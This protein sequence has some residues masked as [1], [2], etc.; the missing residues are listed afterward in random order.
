VPRNVSAQQTRRRHPLPRE[1]HRDRPPSSPPS[2]RRGD[3]R[4]TGCARHSRSRAAFTHRPLRTR[5]AGSHPERQGRHAHCSPVYAGG[6]LRRVPTRGGLETGPTRH[7][8][9]CRTARS[10]RHRASAKGGRAPCPYPFLAPASAARIGRSWTARHLAWRTF[11]V[12]WEPP[13]LTDVSPDPIAICASGTNATTSLV[14]KVGVHPG[15]G[16]SPAA[17]HGTQVRNEPTVDYL[18][19]SGH[20]R[21]DGCGP[22]RRRRSWRRTLTAD[23]LCVPPGWHVGRGQ[24]TP[25]AQKKSLATHGRDSCASCPG[26]LR[27]SSGALGTRTSPRRRGGGEAFEE[28]LR[29]GRRVTPALQTAAALLQLGAPITSPPRWTGASR[30][31]RAPR[32]RRQSPRW[33]APAARRLSPTIPPLAERRAARA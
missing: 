24:H 6:R 10:R 4:G 20:R 28:F 26:L 9:G 25:H 31:I 29:L 17:R 11:H 18:S 27:W 30:T 32:Q 2:G 22:A 8:R 1:P 33:R 21:A 13:F 5:D 23:G 3:D 12:P 15:T 14:A 7:L 16:A 19:G